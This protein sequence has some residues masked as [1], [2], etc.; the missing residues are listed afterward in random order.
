MADELFIGNLTHNDDWGQV[1]WQ[2]DLGETVTTPASGGAVQ[3][4]IKNTLINTRI[5][6]F[7]N[8]TSDSKNI[9]YGFANENAKNTWLTLTNNGT[10][11]DKVN[12][13]EAKALVLDYCEQPKAAPT[14]YFSATLEVEN[15][16]VVSVDGTVILNLLF[17]AINYTNPDGRPTLTPTP[18][19][20]SGT[21]HI[22]KYNKINKN[23]EEINLVENQ[24][25]NILE[26]PSTVDS[27]NYTSIN[28]SSVVTEGETLL[29]AYIECEYTGD[30]Y[31]SSYTQ[32]N[33]V[34]TTVNLSPQFNRVQNISNMANK[35]VTLGYAISGLVDKQ[36]TVT[37][38]SQNYPGIS[39]VYTKTFT[40]NENYYSSSPW[41]IQLVDRTDEPYKIFNSGI[42]DIKA[43]ISAR[44]D[45]KKV[46]ID[47][48]P[49]YSQL[50]VINNN[51]DLGPKVVLNNINKT[52]INWSINKV[53]DY[54][55]NDSTGNIEI[56]LV[57][58]DDETNIYFQT[59]ESD[60]KSGITYDFKPHLEIDNDNAEFNAKLV[61]T[62][63]D[64][65]TELY[66]DIFTID[67]QLGFAPEKGAQ[68]IFN[69]KL[70]DNTSF[71]G[72]RSN[73][74]YIINEANKSVVSATYDNF[75]FNID[76]F[77]KDESG[78]K[79][80][81]VLG[82]QQLNISYH[83]FQKNLTR[84]VV[85]FI[86]SIKNPSDE[87][88]PL[89]SIG[90]I[91]ATND[92]YNDTDAVDEF[93]KWADTNP[94]WKGLKIYPYKG[95]F[96]PLSTTNILENDLWLS[97][98]QLIHVALVITSDKSAAADV[99]GHNLV[100][101]YLN[102]I[103]NRVI[104]LNKSVDVDDDALWNSLADFNIK[105][106]HPKTN[107]DIDIYNMRVYHNTN[108]DHHKIFRNYIS[109]LSSVTE[110]NDIYN[111]NDIID[112]SISKPNDIG[113]N[114][115]FSK[116]SYSKCNELKYNTLLWKPCSDA[117]C[118]KYQEKTR[119]VGRAYSDTKDSTQ[120]GDLVIMQYV[121]NSSGEKV[122]DDLRSG[123]VKNLRVKGQG[124]S[125]MGYWKWNQRWEFDKLETKDGTIVKDGD[126]EY[127]EIQMAD[128]TLARLK[129]DTDWE[130]DDD[131]NKI[132]FTKFYPRISENMT[133]ATEEEKAAYITRGYQLAAGDPYAKRLDAKINWASPMQSH[134]MGSVNLYNDMWKKVVKNSEL[135]NYSGGGSFTGTNNGYKSCRVSIR[136]QWFMLF[137]QKE[138]DSEP[139]FYGLVTMGPSKGDKPTFG[140]NK[141]DF[142]DFVMM[143]G[144]DN[145]PK[146]INCGIPWNNVDVYLEPE[147]KEFY[148]YEEIV[149][150]SRKNES[151]WEISMG[152]NGKDDEAYA[153][154]S[155]YKASPVLLKFKD[156]INFCYKCKVN[157]VGYNGTFETFNDV[158][159]NPENNNGKNTSNNEA[160]STSNL[161]W[162]NQIG[163]E[164]K[165]YD[166]YRWEHRYAYTVESEGKTVTKYGHWVP[167]GIEY[168]DDSFDEDG[169]IKPEC[170]YAKYTQFNLKD[171]YEK[172]V[173]KMRN[174][175]YPPTVSIDWNKPFVEVND[176]IIKHRIE[177]YKGIAST[178][179]VKLGSDDSYIIS[180]PHGGI[181]DYVVFEDLLYTLQML[182]LIAASDNWAKN[183]YIY[184]PGIYEE[185]MSGDIVRTHGK[186]S[187]SI[188]K[189]AIIKVGDT[190]KQYGVARKASKDERDSD[191]I[192]KYKLVSKFRFFQD[193][194]DT[195]F[196]L[197]NTG[198]KVKQYYVEE[199]DINPSTRIEYWNAPQNPLFK[200]AY[201]AWDNMAS[202]TEFDKCMC[203]MMGAILSEM[204]K[205]VTGKKSDNPVLDCWDQY[206]G[207]TI[208]EIPATAYNEIVPLLYIDAEKHR[209]EALEDG[210]QPASGYANISAYPQIVG[211]QYIAEKEWF[212]KRSIMFS[213]YATY[214]M[215]KSKDGESSIGALIFRSSALPENAANQ[216]S[217]IYRYKITPSQYLWPVMAIGS[218]PLYPNPRKRIAPG[219]FVTLSGSTD[220]NTNVTISGIHFINRMEDV[221][222]VWVDPTASFQFVGKQLKEF[223]ATDNAD[224]L[225]STNLLNKKLLFSPL[226][227]SF[228]NTPVLK[229]IKI[230]ASY[231]EDE[232]GNKILNTAFSNR[233]TGGLDLSGV[234]KIEDVDVT[235]TN[236]TSITLPL[237]CNLKSLKL[238]NTITK[239]SLNNFNK[240]TNRDLQIGI[241]PGEMDVSNITTIDINKCP[242]FNEY[243]FIKNYF[244]KPNNEKLVN[245]TLTNINWGS[246]QN[247]SVDDLKYL[248]NVRKPNN[249]NSKVVITGDIDLGNTAIDFDTKMLCL[250]NFGNIDSSKNSLR[251]KYK[252]IEYSSAMGAPTIS[253][254]DN[255]WKTGS[256]KFTVNYESFEGLPA[257]DFCDIIWSVDDNECYTIDP[258]TGVLNVKKLPE[259]IQNQNITINCTIQRYK[260]NE[261]GALTDEMEDIKVQQ[262]KVSLSQPLA[263]IGDVVYADGTYGS[264]EQLMDNKTIIGVCIYAD[265]NA[266]NGAEQYKIAAS[267]EIIKCSNEAK[268]VK[269][270]AYYP[271]WGRS[272]ADLYKTA[273][274][275]NPSILSNYMEFPICSTDSSVRRLKIFQDGYVFK[276]NSANYTTLYP[277][278]YSWGDA[279]NLCDIIATEHRAGYSYN[280]EAALLDFGFENYNKTNTSICAGKYNTLHIIDNVIPSLRAKEL[281]G[282]YGV[283]L[284][285]LNDWMNIM[286]ANNQ[287]KGATSKFELFNYIMAGNSPTYDNSVY[288]NYSSLIGSD[289]V[290]TRSHYL[291]NY[292]PAHIY[293]NSYK[294]FSFNNNNRNDNNEELHDNF[295]E[296][297]WFLPS[298]G[299]LSRILCFSLIDNESNHMFIGYDYIINW[300]KKYSE[301]F[302]KL[303]DAI[304]TIDS[305]TVDS[306]TGAGSD[307]LFWSSTGSAY[308]SAVNNTAIYKY[309]FCLGISS[310][311]SIKMYAE[312]MGN[313]T[314][315]HGT[316]SNR[317]NL[318]P[319]VEF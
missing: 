201:L 209:V 10:D 215:F 79:C 166:L 105:I 279:G 174:D 211:D 106:G 6:C 280:N 75:N 244:I 213:S 138:Y 173:T 67:N 260:R 203:K 20:L 290:T 175:G 95:A 169:K 130:E 77:I 1:T 149:E 110:Q 74:Q 308:R 127:L 62:H 34:K 227:L 116:I 135:T 314:N 83:P 50:L 265:P 270:H 32:I 287:F 134:K 133:D 115:A 31:I 147:K 230:T 18:Q 216:R 281:D 98:D 274:S 28:I 307:K 5:S 220:G 235:G 153:T 288:G 161:Y 300:S 43:E 7:Y 182:K 49:I 100:Y 189:G 198:E 53:F 250:S 97:T 204:G 93:D 13:E 296:G 24:I 214:G 232:N 57:D 14:G 146:L 154:L 2:N 212:R 137:E 191:E 178:E 245:I 89:I 267:T 197:N 185:D 23:Y 22:E 101:I 76:G 121:T 88:Y 295:R 318:W 302:K 151:G 152:I 122:L 176:Q 240:L 238:P 87:E 241:E 236:I 48:P 45:G 262:K 124:T 148:T 26:S 186:D 4:Y 222:N 61:I 126:D 132:L 253:G 114:D 41:P 113:S 139:Y 19:M 294:P 9:L 234:T 207:Q 69:P 218:Q 44:V 55:L 221:G 144:M 317:Y 52:I 252:M 125:S 242:N 92:I 293:C 219:E 205:S 128:G 80:L 42:H 195:I 247:V 102:G 39:R 111:L 143:E 239:L 275:Q 172:W 85:E 30:T 276:N 278:S 193:D 285:D 224:N 319:C 306:N 104:E 15:K 142:P 16:N 38:T 71:E 17:R 107:T 190:V 298:A 200:T 141:K 268:D 46:D 56:K 210:S 47:V 249:S 269:T 27:K 255:I 84:C 228:Q 261:F 54:I 181:S 11:E 199:S 60:V 282:G 256:Y 81:R 202:D 231:S 301:A 168:T 109:G 208:K 289:D 86:Y 163:N 283:S 103:I 312:T 35:Q 167:A 36:L 21:L 183:T 305:T 177:T 277:T 117:R 96:N 264:P 251:I 73:N 192:Q 29:R 315:N 258:K 108:L 187:G 156:L 145:G 311:G 112:E 165:K 37:I 157:L 170:K 254:T 266:A 179:H 140:Y 91:D 120:P 303:R 155:N 90:G 99:Y 188:K 129:K 291:A 286:N 123:T 160:I 292:Y 164:N 58:I 243:D 259:S 237:G 63:V 131:G 229:K 217:A 66:S 271:I 78:R 82:G 273:S 226:D 33:V 206:Y 162:M 25:P 272:S 309:A 51:E 246:E 225:Y 3:S 194:L 248:I 158:Y 313:S 257:N 171:E 150:G 68:F 284:L 223:V 316:K 12:S 136:Q 297:K 94:K 118:S 72:I 180:K 159:N 8:V 70:Y 304:N 184:N 65:G 64:S 233:I 310:V 59:I 119:V 263:K 196:T 40:K 299:E